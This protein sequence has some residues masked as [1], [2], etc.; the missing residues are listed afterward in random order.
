MCESKFRDLFL[1]YQTIYNSETG[2]NIVF[3]GSFD[4]SKKGDR[5][6]LLISFVGR[7]NGLVIYNCSKDYII[8]DDYI[9]NT[10][11]KTLRINDV[12][13]KGII[14]DLDSICDFTSA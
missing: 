6:Y 8:S 13:F 7:E 11:Q 12:Y 14:D 10:T 4:C 5:Y 1:K 2:R 3:S 9:Q